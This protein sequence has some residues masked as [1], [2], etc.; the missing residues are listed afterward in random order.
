MR[1]VSTKVAEG[2]KTYVTFNNFFLEN[3]AICDI[4]WKN[5]V[6]QD[7]PQISV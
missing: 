4:M 7:R 1:N 3:H 5:T 6:V 2:I